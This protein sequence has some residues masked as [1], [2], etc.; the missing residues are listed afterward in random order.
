MMVIVAVVFALCTMLA[1]AQP[2][3]APPAETVGA[4]L[5]ALPVGPEDLIAVSVYGSPEMSRSLRVSEDGRIR[6]PMLNE[7]IKVLGLMPSAI[8]AV[9]AQALV[10]E[11]VLVDPA[12]TVTIGEYRSHPISV[13]G[14]V[15]KPV[16]FQAYGNVTVLDALARA[17]GLA[18]DAGPEILVSRL[19]KGDDG[20]VRTLVQRIPVRGLIDAADP[21]LNLK[22]EGGEEIRV[23][24]AGKVF[25]LGNV[26]KPGAFPVD[27]AND[28]TVL[29]MLALS[30]G[31]MSFSSK[32]AYIYRREGGLGGKKNEIEIPLQKIV[33][34][35]APDVTLQAN[36]ILYI[37]DDSGKRAT[38]TVLERIAG[39]GSSTASGVLIYKH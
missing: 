39:F 7:P 24:E 22:L 20:R 4:N 14:S 27:D 31:L 34:R 18:P 11:Q 35:K 30:E 32:V 6:M 15:R 23:P 5:P 29:K 36:D 9:I 17:E 38:A 25:V 10:S 1:A 8:E 33:H 3:S 12:V 19:H 37:P 21:E 28:T 13:A 2:Q 26:K 16:T